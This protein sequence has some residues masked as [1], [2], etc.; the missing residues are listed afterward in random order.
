MRRFCSDWLK[1]DLKGGRFEGQD[2]S[3]AEDLE[4]R[5]LIFAQNCFRLGS[6][7]LRIVFARDSMPVR[8]HEVR[9]RLHSQQHL[10]HQ[11]D[12]FDMIAVDRRLAGR[13]GN[14]LV[15]I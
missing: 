11:G 1:E 9:P 5:R 13:P 6:F 15:T 2:M 10:P 14:D 7:A 3:S 12:F 4:T 8:K